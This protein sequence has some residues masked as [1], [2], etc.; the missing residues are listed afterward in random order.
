MPP[1]EQ[2]TSAG[3]RSPASIACTPKRLPR[4]CWE[5]AARKAREINPMNFAPVHRLAQVMPD[6]APTRER[7]AVVT[8]KYWGNQG[9][10]LTVGFL[11][12]P[13]SATRRK[14]LQ[15]LNAWERTANVQFVET[16]ANA[17]VR[18]ARIPDG[19]WSYLGTDIMDESIRPDQPTMNLDAFTRFTEDSEYIR[20]VRHEAGHTLGFPHEHMRAELIELIDREK[21][22]DHFMRTQGWSRQEV[23]NQVLT[24]L[25]ES[26]LL[27]TDNAEEDSIMCYQIS[28]DITV[29][30]DPINGGTDITESDAAFAGKIYPKPKPLELGVRDREVGGVPVANDALTIEVTPGLTRINVKRVG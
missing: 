6:F 5:R 22:I 3:R 1:N 16:N 13:D 17:Q 23:I 14:I 26:S 2:Y 20:V 24:P 21:A 4:D 25:E 8:T 28:G 11:D 7:L 10:R 18:I 19:F 27:G 30:G 29:N 12:N 9:V 15:N